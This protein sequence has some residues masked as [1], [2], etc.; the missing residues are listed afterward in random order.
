[1][2]H[3]TV[4]SLCLYAISFLWYRESREQF[5]PRQCT[6]ACIACHELAIA[7]DC[8]GIL[9]G[10]C[11][12]VRLAGW[13]GRCRRLLRLLQQGKHTGRILALL[14]E[15]RLQIGQFLLDGGA[16]LLVAL[17]LLP[18]GEGFFG[19]GIARPHKRAIIAAHDLPRPLLI[20]R[21][22]VAKW[23]NLAAISKVVPLGSARLCFIGRA[24][25][26]RCAA[27][28]RRLL[29]LEVGL[30]DRACVAQQVTFLRTLRLDHKLGR[31]T[32]T[33]REDLVTVNGRDNDTVFA[34][35]TTEKLGLC[36]WHLPLHAQ[37]ARIMQAPI[38]LALSCNRHH[39]RLQTAIFL[40]HCT[41]QSASD[42]SLQGLHHKA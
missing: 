27:A 34:K 36:H 32:P 31:T 10:L 11:L 6:I 22:S 9:Q 14:R 42:P 29:A 23:F 26:D 12:A 17:R 19:R 7:W 24:C 41:M 33:H 30:Q 39:A 13:L 35:K 16:A 28:Q 5:R 25:Q 2:L 8:K 21:G 15:F 4:V 37:S 40:S 3:C 1:M 18:R 20:G 38:A